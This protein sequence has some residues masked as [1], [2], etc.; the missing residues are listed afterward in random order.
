[1]TPAALVFVLASSAYAVNVAFGAS[2]RVRWLDSS[3]FR[4]VHHGL[5]I[6]T[7]ALTAAAVS[8]LFWSSTHAGWWLLPALIPLAALPY[9]GSARKRP[10]RHIAA[11]LVP[12]PFY[13]LGLVVAFAA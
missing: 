3:R 12:L 11:A 4:W 1:M 5:Y 6:L 8:S 13:I 9:L 2:V 10:G 7:F